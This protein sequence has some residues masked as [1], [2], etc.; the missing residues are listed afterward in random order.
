[1]LYDSRCRLCAFAANWLGRQRQ[2]VPL[3]LVP[4]GSA[5]ARRRF[6]ALDHAAAGK[7][8]TVIGDAGQVYRGDAAWVVCLWALA[9]HRAF[10]HTLTTPAGRR[11][12]RAAVLSAAKYRASAR[13]TAGPAPTP[14]RAPVHRRDK[15]YAV[16]PGWT[17]DRVNGWT[18]TPS[19]PKDG[20]PKGPS[21]GRTYEGDGHWAQVH[22]G[23]CAGPS[24][25]GCE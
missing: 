4:A 5:E 9:D 7:D 22:G 15:T 3:D 8:V 10:S 13:H 18:P 23:A 19:P 24:D 6:P 25:E 16:T 17:Y 20:S 1:V 12:A 21:P 14:A 2:F 11:L